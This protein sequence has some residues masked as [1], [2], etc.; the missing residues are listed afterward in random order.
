MDDLSGLIDMI[1]IGDIA[2]KI[3]IDENV[4]KAAVAIAVPA[5]VGGLA[6]NAKDKEGAKSLESALGH[7]K[8]RA[9]KKLDDIDE[10]DGEKIVSHV[11]GS[12]TDKVVE[13][14]AAKADVKTGGIDFGAIVAQVLPIVAPIVLAY[15]ANQFMGKKPEAEVKAEPA[16]EPAESANPLA[17]MLGG[18]LSSPQGQE[19]I[20]GALGSLLGGSRK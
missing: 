2:K 10:K 15:V 11:F 4:A 16:A 6:N 3:G 20:S 12:K 17:D 14:A 5:I 19:I 13:A 1:P 7:H 9:P 8:G 18:L